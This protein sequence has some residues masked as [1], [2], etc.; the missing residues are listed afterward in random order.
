VHP[1]ALPSTQALTGASGHLALPDAMP[2]SLT[3]LSAPA[4]AGPRV[5][6][7]LPQLTPVAPAA[8]QVAAPDAGRQEGVPGLVTGVA[9]VALLATAGAQVAARR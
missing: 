2:Y 6:Q 7:V 1:A 5:A 9:I 4:V 3:G 8:G